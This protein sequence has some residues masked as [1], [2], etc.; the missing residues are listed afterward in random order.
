MHYPEWLKVSANAGTSNSFSSV[1]NLVNDMKLKTVC[2]EAKCPNII[3]CFN[4]LTAT[5]LIMGDI[6]TR[7]CS[8][9]AIKKGKPQMLSLQEP[10]HIAAAVKKLNLDYVVITSVTRDDLVDGGVAHYLACVDCI[11]ELNGD[12]DIELLIPD[13][14]GNKKSIDAI[15]SCS[16][17]V[18]NHNIETVKRLY[19]QVRSGASYEQSLN[20]IEYIKITAPH[21][22][23]KSGLMLGL[24]E[25][26]EEIIETLSDLR[27]MGCEFLTMGQYLAPTEKHFPVV[28]YLEP[29]C[30]ERYKAFALKLG[31][32]G[33]VAG[34][35]VRSS[36]LASHLIK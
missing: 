31:F 25:A 15:V 9:C 34:P 3:E 33:V 23:T 27:T 17:K 26:D 36:Y 8:F 19:P 1:E 10:Y 29:E 35:L 30:F 14:S 22:Y 5:F 13:F 11:R 2:E 21:I 24:G 4:N 28:R 7:N 32:S 12:I 16:P 6:C 20:L 18:I